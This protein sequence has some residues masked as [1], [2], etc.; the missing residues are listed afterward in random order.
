MFRAYFC[1]FSAYFSTFLH[2][3][4]FWVEFWLHIFAQ[5]R[6][7]LFHPGPQ[8]QV[9]LEQRPAASASQS[10]SLPLPVPPSVPI[11]FLRFSEN[12]ISQDQTARTIL[13]LPGTAAPPPAAA[14]WFQAT[15]LSAAPVLLPPSAQL[16]KPL[17]Y[18]F[19]IW[20]DPKTLSPPLELLWILWSSGKAT[21]CHI[22]TYT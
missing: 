6:Q 11:G 9:R 15:Q 19:T 2:F 8:I 7:P 17:P 1:I 10:A 3:F 20:G 14:A 4:C 13:P 12:L 21:P 5:V 16:R 22:Q 18:S